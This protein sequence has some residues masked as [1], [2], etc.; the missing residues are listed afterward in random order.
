MLYSDL[1]SDIYLQHQLIDVSGTLYSN[2]GNNLISKI[3]FS[4]MSGNFKLISF[5]KDIVT[6]L[7]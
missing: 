6:K 3:T 7:K 1:I 2:I 4:N 5:R